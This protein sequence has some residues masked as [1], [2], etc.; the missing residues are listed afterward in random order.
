MRFLRNIAKTAP[1]LGCTATGTSLNALDTNIFSAGP[2]VQG[3]RL[4]LQTNLS[5]GA[6]RPVKIDTDSP[7][8]K[9]C[10]FMVHNLLAPGA[11]LKAISP[12]AGGAVY[13]SKIAP[14]AAA[15]V[16]QAR[17]QNEIERREIQIG[18]PY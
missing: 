12:A 13:R 3:L 17:L 4:R 2:G 11:K 10:K 5:P 1:L 14:H 15:E 6:R 18:G 8:Y 7:L 9:G 16:S